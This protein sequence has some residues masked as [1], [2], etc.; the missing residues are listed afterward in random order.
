LLRLE[1]NNDGL[2]V[3]IQG[4]GIV[5]LHVRLTFI[6]G[7]SKGQNPMACHF[8]AFS[9]NI[10]IIVPDF[11]HST[12]HDNIIERQRNPTKKQEMD[13][14]I[15]RCSA[16]IKPA[17]HGTMNNAREYLTSVFKM[18]VISAFREL[19]YMLEVVFYHAAPK[20]GGSMV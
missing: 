6:V 7:D 5:Y 12:A 14:I 11:D 8:G 10:K 2:K 4:L 9:A 15:D 19:E 18:G 17:K 20:K 1:K 16:A 13:D 3:D